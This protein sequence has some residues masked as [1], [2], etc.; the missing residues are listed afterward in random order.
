MTKTTATGPMRADRR[1]RGNASPVAFASPLTFQVSSTPTSSFNSARPWATFE[2][3]L[4]ESAE[5]L[6]PSSL[7][8]GSLPPGITLSPSGL[9]FGLPTQVGDFRPVV[10]VTDSSV[11]ADTETLVLRVVEELTVLPTTAPPAEVGV[12]LTQPVKLAASGG[13]APSTWTVAQG[14]AL[15]VGLTLNPQTGEI[16]GAP[17]AGSYL[18]E[19]T[20]TDQSRIRLD[21]R[22]GELVGI[23]RQA[24]TFQVTVESRDRFGTRARAILVLAVRP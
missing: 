8:S 4:T 15:P 10:K 23:P 22:R 12:P 14:T 7:R 21:S 24:G 2:R 20:V 9:L 6:P 13:T 5:A 11:R 3:W 19:R 18:L 1:G 16:T 17:A